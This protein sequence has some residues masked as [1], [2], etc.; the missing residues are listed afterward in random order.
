MSSRRSL[1]KGFLSFSIGPWLS[2]LVAFVTTPLITWLLSPEEFGRGSLFLTAYGL[3]ITMVLLG[4]DG[5]YVR[6]FH[7]YN[8][9]R[10]RASSLLLTFLVTP[11][12]TVFLF[13]LFLGLF[14]EEISFLLTGTSDNAGSMMLFLG[15]LLLVGVLQ[16]FALLIVRMQQKGVLF[17]LLT[18]L[19]S[20]A[21]AGF[22]IGYSLLVR[23]DFNAMLWGRLGGLSLT[24][25]AA[26]LLVERTL[27][28]GFFRKRVTLNASLMKEGF[29]YGLPL[30]PAELLT[31][32]LNSMDKI[33]LRSFSSFS[34][35]GLYTAANKLLSALLL[36]RTSFSM[37]WV[38]VAYQKYEDDGDARFFGKVARIMTGLLFLLA[39]GVILA[40]DLVVLL[41]AGEYRGAASVMPFLVFVP[42]MYTLSE[43]TM[44][45][46]NFKKQTHWHIVVSGISVV[47]N[48]VGNYL[49]VPRFGAKG[50]A[51]ATGGSYIVFFY[52]R[53]IVSRR[54]FP[55]DYGMVRITVGVILLMSVAFVNTF[56]PSL[57]GM[58]AAGVGIGVLGVLYV[59]EIRKGF[60]FGIG[61]LRSRMMRKD[62]DSR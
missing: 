25:L 13:S 14:K 5:A 38:P 10:E 53:T 39:M 16:R 35:I 51:I 7:Q 40:K 15:L 42:T 59:H 4:F 58:A 50:A 6:Y 33:A 9:S 62:L 22:I 48:L 2:A 26:S 3:L 8:D 55:V 17:S 23:K 52:M 11:L 36:L 21:N 27:W 31:W 20:L 49:L 44:V 46:I 60:S 12:T 61:I 37:F 57:W 43:V 30:V 47:V 41:L 34:E 56:L 18:L 1:V 54:L 19:N 28:I 32:V 45:G 29:L 24:F